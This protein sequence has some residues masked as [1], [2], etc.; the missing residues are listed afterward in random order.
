MN[1]NIEKMKMIYIN[2]LHKEYRNKALIF[3]L[4]FT[5]LAI[6]VLNGMVSWI[7]ESFLDPNL[8]NTIGD[9]SA[10]V[11][12]YFINFWASLLGV[13]LGAGT[14]RSDFEDNVMSQLLSFPIKRSEYLLA[15]ILGTWT[16]VLIFFVISLTAALAL[17]SISAKEFFFG[18]D[19]I[20]ALGVCSLQFLTS[21]TIAVVLSYYLPK[22][23]TLLSALFLTSLMSTANVYYSGK[24]FFHTLTE[25]GVSFIKVVG[26]LFH[27][28]LPRVGEISTVTNDLLMGKGLED[29]PFLTFSHFILSYSLLFFIASFILKRK[30]L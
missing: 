21:I 13:L 4:I 23:F 20:L 18:F 8:G 9:K 14:I 30:D 3:L 10:Y 22:I 26:A 15:R 28:F 27:A 2:T 29:F 25:N 5:L 17:L 6:A 11:F 12:F 1:L 16:I 24:E 19:T 7:Y